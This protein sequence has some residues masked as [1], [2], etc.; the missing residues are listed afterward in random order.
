MAN[1]TISRARHAASRVQDVAENAYNSGHL[2]RARQRLARAMEGDKPN[3]VLVQ[4]TA[5]A[6]LSS[7]CLRLLQTP[8][9]GSFIARWAPMFVF[10]AFYQRKLEGRRR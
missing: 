6:I 7:V 2:R 8:G 3:D 4:A 1:V 10:A 9:V 5:A